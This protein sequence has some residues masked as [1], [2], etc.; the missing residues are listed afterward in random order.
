MSVT[1]S[2]EPE[3]RLPAR[4]PTARAFALGWQM[5][6]VYQGAAE[7]PTEDAPASETLPSVAGLTSGQ[8]TELAIEEIAAGLHYFEPQLLEA[9]IEAPK[10]D[11]IR[12]TFRERESRE[13]LR[14]EIGRLHVALLASLSALDFR[15]AKAYGLGRALHDTCIQAPSFEALSE[16]FEHENFGTIEESLSDLATV[17]PP[18]SARAVAVSLGYWRSW[19]VEPKID[20]RLVSW[21]QDAPK[22]S[23]YLFRQAKL[24]RGLLSGEKAAEDTLDAEG[25]VSAARVAF[26]RFRRLLFAYA[27]RLWPVT[28]LV[29]ALVLVAVLLLWRSSGVHSDLG[30]LAAFVGALG[31]SWRSA[32]STTGKIAASLET[33]V[34]GAALDDAIGRSIVCL[35]TVPKNPAV[36][37]PSG[38][39]LAPRGELT[40]AD[41][42]GAESTA[43]AI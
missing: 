7:R 36:T 39:R 8:Q 10:I 5:S 22:I 1:A 40:A 41:E 13:K 35:P 28:I 17:L 12:Q 9:K 43:S 23:D 19:C 30:A 24:W 16:R 34:W 4:G 26:S 33:P 32:A 42:P 6:E 15:L 21:S 38:P 14:G 27:L 29:L 11:E 37:A 25:Y 20:G 31:I 3:R 2:I 18:H